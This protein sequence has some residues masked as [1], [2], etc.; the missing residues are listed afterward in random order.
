MTQ[1][2][3]Q[4]ESRFFLEKHYKAVTC[5]CGKDILIKVG[6][7]GS[8]GA[9][10]ALNKAMLLIDPDDPD[11]ARKRQDL[12]GVF[13]EMLPPQEEV[14]EILKFIRQEVKSREGQGEILF[15]DQR[16]LLTS[17]FYGPWWHHCFHV[18]MN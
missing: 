12:L 11:H 1:L 17:L 15:M 6:F 9:E 4:W 3:R 8:E 10:N 5:R 16:Q 2:K 14:D 7:D 18:P 13:L